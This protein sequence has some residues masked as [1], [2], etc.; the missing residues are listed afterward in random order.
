MKEV[1]L[2]E[3][4]EILANAIKNFFKDRGGMVKTAFS[5]D[6]ADTVIGS[7]N[8]PIGEGIFMIIDVGDY[9]EKRCLKTI[10]NFKDKFP[11]STVIVIA[12]LIN[13][14]F[15]INARKAGATHFIDMGVSFWDDLEKNAQ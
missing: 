11:Q 1:L 8:L 10:E 4:C 5:K 15:A 13:G 14:T 6:E 2:V 9:E 3:E 12:P 7:L